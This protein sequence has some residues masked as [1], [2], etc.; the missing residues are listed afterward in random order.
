MLVMIKLATTFNLLLL[1]ID[2]KLWDKKGS[3]KQSLMEKIRDRKV[4]RGIS[5][6]SVDILNPT[7]VADQSTNKSI[8]T[9]VI[10]HGMHTIKNGAQRLTDCPS[11]NETLLTIMST[12]GAI[13]D[14]SLE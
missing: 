1:I 6:A 2:P 13:T 11:A 10:G 12:A 8:G 5:T 7:R 4:K 9:P 3:A 14:I